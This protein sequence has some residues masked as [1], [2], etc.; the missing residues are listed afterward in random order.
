MIQSYG[1]EQGHEERGKEGEEIQE[2]IE[3]IGINVS[4]N[5]TIGESLV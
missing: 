5:V 1:K 2:K 3:D 4:E